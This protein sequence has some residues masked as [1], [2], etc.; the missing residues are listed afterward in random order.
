MKAAECIAGQLKPFGDSGTYFQ[1][2]FVDISRISDSSYMRSGAKYFWGSK[3]FLVMPFTAA[4]TS[5]TAPRV[6]AGYGYENES[7]SN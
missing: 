7:Y 5:L 4:D 2:F 3:N 1:R 6:F